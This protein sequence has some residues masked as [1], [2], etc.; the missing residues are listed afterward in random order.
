MIKDDKELVEAAEKANGLIQEIS[1]YLGERNIKDAKLRFPRNYLKTATHYRNKLS[2]ISDQVLLTNSSYTLMLLDVYKWIANRTD[3]WGVPRDMLIKHGIC[4]IGSLCESFTKDALKGRV[5]AKKGYKERTAY[6]AD[7][8]LI[9]KDQ[10]QELD[11]IW[12]TRNN[13]HLFLV[14][15]IEYEHYKASDYNRASSAFNNL[16]A[17]L[18]RL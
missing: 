5:S 4:I 15:F 1:N 11:W 12:D 14:S 8:K 16:C 3:I 17:A 9:D 10:K 6:L 7:K 18:R 2:F 13:Q